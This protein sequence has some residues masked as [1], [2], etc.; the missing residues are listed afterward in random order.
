MSVVPP[1]R[2]QQLEFYEA[3]VPVWQTNATEIGLTTAQVT[4][5]GALVTAARTAYNAQQPARNASKAATTSFYE[6]IDTAHASGA[7]LIATIKAF[8]GTSNDPTVYTTAQIPPPAAPTPAPP[9]EQPTN[10]NATLN[11]D[12]SITLRWKGTVAQSAFFSVWRATAPGTGGQFTTPALIGTVA[13]KAFIDGNVP[14]AVQAQYTIRAHRGT[15]V[16]VPSD[17]TI[18]RIGQPEDS[19]EAGGQGGLSLAA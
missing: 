3:H 10:L 9:P 16:S 15:A 14:V 2:L 7:E 6:A 18:V 1:T 4:A 11:T 5:L 12:G 8:A 13:D 17:P 19:E